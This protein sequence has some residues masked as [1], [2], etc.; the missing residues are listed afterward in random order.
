MKTDIG[1]ILIFGGT[2]FFGKSLI[3]YLT[4]GNRFSANT[5]YVTT[6][7]P[8]KYRSTYPFNT[9]KNVYLIDFDLYGTEINSELIDRHF[10]CIIHAAAA[11]TDVSG[12]S[13]LNRLHQITNGTEKILKYVKNHQSHAKFLYVSSGGVYGEMDPKIDSFCEEMNTLP[14]FDDRNNTYSISKRMAEHICFLYADQFG[15][16]VTIA[17][18]FAFSGKFLPLDAHFAIGNFIL[19]ASKN[20]DIIIRGNGTPVRSYL[21]QHDLSEWLLV[22]LQNTASTAAVY[23]VGSNVPISIEGLAHKIKLISGSNSSVIVE[24]SEQLNRNIYIPDTRK[25]TSNFRLAETVS[26]DSSIRDMLLNI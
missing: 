22:L 6:R 9:F 5:I 2:G 11:S 1:N 17:R 23:N 20:Q 14:A 24:D 12:L 19:N 26:L 16:K 8:E 4:T 15:L 25:I 21:D 18:C 3:N 7:E 13:S 10:D